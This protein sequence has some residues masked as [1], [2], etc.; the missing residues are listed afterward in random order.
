MALH[1]DLYHEI[2]REAKQRQRDPLKLAM[3]GMLVIAVGMVGY[4]LTR[5]ATVSRLGGRAAQ[6]AGEWK[7]MSE[8]QE[9]AKVREAELSEK[10]KSS[11]TIVQRIESR[12]YWAP[13]LEQILHAVPREVQITKFE[14]GASLDPVTDKAKPNEA[15]KKCTMG[16][17]GVTA[18]DEPRTIAE[19]L[20][21][22]LG[23]NLSQ[24]YDRVS[25]VFKGLE[26][27][28]DSIQLDG[29]PR[30]MA[31]FGINLELHTT[32]PAA[33]P[34]QKGIAANA[35]PVRAG[36]NRAESK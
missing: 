35:A 18:G 5:M 25:S 20:R 2:R 10:I 29:R 8:K 19:N 9:A 21:T 22:A 36:K 27:T 3:L 12:F 15:L 32:E 23:T 24:K 17:N 6:V 14:G 26:D 7:M 30:P 16:I 31:N 13:L 34:A 33:A 4:Y 1:I 28:A 11:E